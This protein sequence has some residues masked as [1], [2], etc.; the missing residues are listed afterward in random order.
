MRH[1]GASTVASQPEG[2]GFDSPSASIGSL[3]YSGFLPQP[4]DMHV[5]TTGDPK[6]IVGVTSLSPVITAKT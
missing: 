1:S 2:P 3:K 4:E 5:R 6:L